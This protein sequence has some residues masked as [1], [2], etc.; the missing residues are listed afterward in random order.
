MLN[1]NVFVLQ[2][3]KTKWR[4][5]GVVFVCYVSRIL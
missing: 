4:F 3:Q 1:G 2:T 5:D